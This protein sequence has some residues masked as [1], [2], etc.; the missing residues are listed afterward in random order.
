MNE[1]AKA[2]GMK[3]TQY[4]NPEGLTEPATAPPRATWAPWP[5]G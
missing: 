4:K 2:L 1:Q 3:A 5:P